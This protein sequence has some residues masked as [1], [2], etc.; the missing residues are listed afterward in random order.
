MN[1]RVLL[2]R[3]FQAVHFPQELLPALSPFYGFFP[4]KRAQFRDDFLLTADLPL[5]V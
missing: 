5:L 1:V 2:R 3:F 4:V